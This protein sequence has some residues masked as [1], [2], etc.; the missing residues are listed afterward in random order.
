MFSIFS[1]TF[2]LAIVVAMLGV[3]MVTSVI[4]ALFGP[5]K[6]GTSPV[7][8]SIRLFN[9]SQSSNI[10]LLEFPYFAPNMVDFTL[11]SPPMIISFFLF[12]YMDGISFFTL[13]VPVS[14]SGFCKPDVVAVAGQ[15][16]DDGRVVP[17][18]GTPLLTGTG[19]SLP[20]LAP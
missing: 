8:M 9:S 16:L 14:S 15:A 10:R 2:H 1:S 11:K 5:A 12:S 17:I 13:S 18:G 20:P 6:V 3:A 19:V 7:L 4:E